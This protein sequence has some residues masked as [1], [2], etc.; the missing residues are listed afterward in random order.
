LD[1]YLS[2]SLNYLYS[3]KCKIAIDKLIRYN[4]TVLDE[5]N[6]AAHF[7]DRIKFKESLDKK[8]VN[9]AIEE[10]KS[11]YNASN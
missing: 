5:N 7:F 8:E 3:E 6:L 10:F 11:I 1:N 9:K 4:M 2:I